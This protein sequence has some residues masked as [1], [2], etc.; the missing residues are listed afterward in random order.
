MKIPLSNTTRQRALQALGS[1]DTEKLLDVVK[2]TKVNEFYIK[3]LEESL[4]SDAQRIAEV[5]PR[6]DFLPDYRDYA[7][8]TNF[9]GEVRS[10]GRD[11]LKVEIPRMG[12]IGAKR[13]SNERNYG[14]E[15]TVPKGSDYYEHK[16]K[17]PEMPKVEA[18]PQTKKA[19]DEVFDEVE[20]SNNDLGG[21]SGYG[22]F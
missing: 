6:S 1:L 8:Q 20:T 12:K 17:Q 10:K 19:L 2:V 14:T 9:D 3:N 16:V 18:R 21:E 4:A 15:I 13:I 22:T 11:S 5:M 7:K